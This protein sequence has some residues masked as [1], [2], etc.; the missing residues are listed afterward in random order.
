MPRSNHRLTASEIHCK[1][2]EFVRQTEDHLAWSGAAASGSDDPQPVPIARPRASR[3]GATVSSKPSNRSAD[4][5]NRHRSW[6]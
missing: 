5:E 4:L 3:A 1:S 6:K 2:E